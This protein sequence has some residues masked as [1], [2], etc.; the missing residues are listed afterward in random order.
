MGTTFSSF[1]VPTNSI[2]RLAFCFFVLSAC[3]KVI[4][5]HGSFVAKQLR[6]FFSVVFATNRLLA[7]GDSSRHSTVHR[8]PIKRENNQIIEGYQEGA[9][10]KQ[11]AFP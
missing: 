2:A 4:L 11:F 9:A 3:T 7:S 1:L 5:S 10:K 8:E 6:L